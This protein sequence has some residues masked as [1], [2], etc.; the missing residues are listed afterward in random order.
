MCT[1]QIVTADVAGDS[2]AYSK[3]SGPEAN[4]TEDVTAGRQTLC[5]LWG[6]QAEADIKVQNKMNSGKAS[7]D[8]LNTDIS[9]LVLVLNKV[10]T[11]RMRAE[12]II[13]H[14]C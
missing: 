7:T 5:E 13:S 14:D 6:V 11:P 4:R 8:C 9:H 12:K 2:A 10:G 3:T 1:K